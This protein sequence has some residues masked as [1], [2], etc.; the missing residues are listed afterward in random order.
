M[1]VWLAPGPH[2]KWQKVR[3]LKKVKVSALNRVLSLCN[4]MDY[5]LP[6]SSVHG[7][8]WARILEWVVISSFL[9]L[10]LTNSHF[11]QQISIEALQHAR[12]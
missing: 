3:G 4:L 2:S 7:I 9:T 8:L 1:Q 6:G 12:R 11:I 10:R 5:S